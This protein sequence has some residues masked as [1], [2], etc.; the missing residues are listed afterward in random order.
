MFRLLGFETFYIWLVNMQYKFKIGF[1]TQTACTICHTKMAKTFNG[2]RMGDFWILYNSFVNF[3]I[4]VS[5]R[6][7]HH[8]SQTPKQLWTCDSVYQKTQ[9]ILTT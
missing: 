1:I 6:Y 3:L 9:I 8:L 4:Q 2:K 7:C 5:S